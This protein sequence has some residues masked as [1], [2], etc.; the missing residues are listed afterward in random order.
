MICGRQTGK[1]M[2]LLVNADLS[3]NVGLAMI[4]P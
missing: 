3:R 2:C 4:L 1:L